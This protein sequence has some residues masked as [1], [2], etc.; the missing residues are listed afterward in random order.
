MTARDDRGRS[1][2]EGDPQPTTIEWTPV[3]G[4]LP[5]AVYAIDYSGP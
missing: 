5:H 3:L 4:A 1:W 2:L